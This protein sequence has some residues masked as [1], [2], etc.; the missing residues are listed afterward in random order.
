MTAVGLSMSLGAFLAGVLLADSNT[1]TSWKPPSSRSKAVAGPVLHLG[2]HVCRPRRDR[3]RAVTI[4][5][6]VI[7]LMLVKR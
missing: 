1:G 3:A 2:R 6:M 7:G 4:V 5:A